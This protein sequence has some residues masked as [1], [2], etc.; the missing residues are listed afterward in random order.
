MTPRLQHIANAPPTFILDYKP[1]MCPTGEIHEVRR[2]QGPGSLR[3]RAPRHQWSDSRVTSDPSFL[4]GLPILRQGHCSDEVWGGSLEGRGHQLGNR[5]VRD[6]RV[7]VPGGNTCVMVDLGSDDPDS[8]TDTLK[9]SRRRSWRL[10][11]SAMNQG[12]SSGSPRCKQV[13]SEAF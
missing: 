5:M 3:V 10:P 13:F 9:P 4:K 12:H 11:E 1:P 2:V 7:C 8:P 6:V